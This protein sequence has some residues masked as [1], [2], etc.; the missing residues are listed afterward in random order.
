MKNELLRPWKLLS[1]CVGLSLLIYGALTQ[2]ACDWD[3]GVSVIM[4]GYTYI[5]AP[6]F[7]KT[8][9]AA[10]KGKATI[11]N[12]LIAMFIFW[13]TVDGSYMLYHTAMGN[14]T[15]RYANFCASSCLYLICGMIW[16]Y[17]GDLVDLFQF[18]KELT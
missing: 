15:L 17:D 3:I 9:F 13:F 10:Y 7:C 12:V 11:Q 6:F 16:L 5:S 8:A 1:L 2:E 18:L 4:A 14:E